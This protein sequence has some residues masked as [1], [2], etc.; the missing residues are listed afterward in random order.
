MENRGKS[1]EFP[2]NSRDEKWMKFVILIKFLEKTFLK[3]MNDILGFSN[4]K[5]M[6]S[7]VNDLISSSSNPSFLAS[8]HFIPNLRQEKKNKWIWIFST[9]QFGC[10]IRQFLFF[11]PPRTLLLTRLCPWQIHSYS[12]H[13]WSQIKHLFYLLGFC[14]IRFCCVVKCRKHKFCRCRWTR[15]LVAYVILCLLWARRRASQSF[16]LAPLAPHRTWKYY[17]TYQ[18][19][20]N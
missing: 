2:H 9:F 5:F 19:R 18:R 4:L 7:R 17:T 20:P 3:N 13:V 6:I 12:I 11:S 14:S 10:C 15:S 16:L 8:L 1:F